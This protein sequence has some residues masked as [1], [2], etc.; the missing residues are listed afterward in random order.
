[1]STKTTFLPILA[2]FLIVLMVGACTADRNLVVLSNKHRQK[3]DVQCVLSGM[4]T[5]EF[6]DSDLAMLPDMATMCDYIYRSTSDSTHRP[7]YDTS[8]GIVHKFESFFLRWRSLRSFPSFPVS[9]PVLLERSGLVYD[10]WISESGSK[11]VVVFRGTDFGTFIDWRT[12]A[13]WLTQ[14]SRK[15]SNQYDEVR[16]LMPSLIDSIRR[17]CGVGVTLYATGHSLGGGLAMQA[18]YTSADLKKV[19]TFHTSPVDGYKSIDDFDT[20]RHVN[21]KRF[22]RVYEKGEVL[23][24]LRYPIDFFKPRSLANPEVIQMKFN[25][26]RGNLIR[27]HL[28]PE[29]ATKLREIKSQ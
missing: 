5:S 28:M 21:G 18:A 8:Y 22:Y 11:A 4:P 29:F 9:R 20:P 7:V 12:N 16:R 19:F 25:L 13:F 27:E 2:T 1:M 17:E 24:A 6:N 15:Y 23:S 26:I 10:V 14:F 3:T